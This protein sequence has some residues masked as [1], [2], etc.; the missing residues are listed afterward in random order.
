MTAAAKGFGQLSAADVLIGTIPLGQLVAVTNNSPNPPGVVH[1]VTD[2]V[3]DVIVERTIDGAS[4][5]VVQLFDPYRSLLRSGMFD[6]GLALTLD[7][8]NFALVAFAKTG[9]QLQLTFEAAA[10]YNL[11]QQKGPKAYGSSTN[12]DGFV[13]MLVSAVP[14]VKLVCQPGPVSFTTGS[15]ATASTTTTTV[16]PIARGTTSLPDEDSW[17]CINRLANSAG[18]RAFECEGTIY[19]GSDAWLLTNMPPGGTLREFTTT[20]QIIDGTYDVGMPLG[21]LTVTAMTVLWPY[22]PGTPVIVAEMGRF[23]GTWLV[24]SMQ[25]DFFKPQASIT[26]QIPMAPEQVRLGLPTLQYV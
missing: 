19:I 1:N 8:L 24:Y 16:A 10:A 14:G 5:V 13:Q 11:R 15:G 20:V 22:K 9:D 2:A 21:Q 23:S 17:T 3:T 18:W 25:R 12:L 6:F 26:L 4:T 7:G